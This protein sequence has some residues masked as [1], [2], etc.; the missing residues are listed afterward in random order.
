MAWNSWINNIYIY[1][2]P[3]AFT[4][5]FYNYQVFYRH[6]FLWS[7]QTVNSECHCLTKKERREAPPFSWWQCLLSLSLEAQDQGREGRYW[8]VNLHVVSALLPATLTTAASQSVCTCDPGALGR[9]GL[10]TAPGAQSHS[11]LYGS[12][13]WPAVLFSKVSVTCSQ[14]QS[15]NLQG[16][17]PEISNW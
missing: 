6:I 13:S 12:S 9:G 1:L 3:W 10:P 4:Q 14:L 11:V 16:K 15:K 7:S 5:A 2:A 17:I 8:A